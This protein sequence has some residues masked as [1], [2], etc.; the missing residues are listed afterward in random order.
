MQSQNNLKTLSILLNQLQNDSCIF[1][2]FQYVI[3]KSNRG[4]QKRCNLFIVSRMPFLYVL[5][6]LIRNNDLIR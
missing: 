5:Y 3:R 4:L 1:N 2:I 6:S